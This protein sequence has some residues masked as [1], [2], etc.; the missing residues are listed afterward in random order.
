M[1]V[2]A[3][4][5]CICAA[6]APIQTQAAGRMTTA[7][8][9]L[10]YTQKIKNTKYSNSQLHEYFDK[11]TRRILPR[12]LCAPTTTSINALTTVYTFTSIGSCS[13]SIPAATSNIQVLA[14]GG[15]GGGTGSRGGGGGGGQVAAVQLYPPPGQAVTIA[16]GAAGSSGSGGSASS[17]TFGTSVLSVAGGNAGALCSGY[18]AMTGCSNTNAGG[19]GLTGLGSVT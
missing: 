16:V 17:V 14:V 9:S 5:L 12:T 2:W 1:A 18:I 8:D 15:G 7:D 6:L 19:A 3:I 10:F 11:N 4:F 13:W